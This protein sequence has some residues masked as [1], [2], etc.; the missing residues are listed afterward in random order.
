MHLRWMVGVMSRWYEVKVRGLLGPEAGDSKT[1]RILNRALVWN[2]DGITYEGDDKHAK[3]IVRELGLRPDSNGIDVPMDRDDA[4][5]DETTALDD[6]HAR[7]YRRLAATVDFMAQDRPDLQLPASI[8]GRSMSRPTEGSW[9]RLK[10]VGRYLVKH[11][12]VVW[13]YKDVLADEVQEIV[14]WSESD[15]AGCRQTRRNAAGKAAAEALAAQSLMA[16]L[17]WRLRPHLFVD[18]SA[19]QGMAT[20][21]GIGRVRHLDVRFLWLQQTVKS[22]DLRLSKVWGHVNPAD[23]LTKPMS[24]AASMRVLEQVALR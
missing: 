8:L 10:K 12:S 14:V 21:Q 24:F 7:R 3:T 19:A 18:A 22:G 23:A 1:I 11:P 9:A 4:R 5:E 13:E 6:E 2:D 16:D 15:W 17:G 20:R